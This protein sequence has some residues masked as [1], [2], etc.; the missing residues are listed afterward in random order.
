[1]VPGSW[2]TLLLVAV[3]AVVLV[4]YFVGYFRREKLRLRKW[5]WYEFYWAWFGK[6]WPSRPWG[7]IDSLAGLLGLLV[8]AGFGAYTYFGGGSV[9]K[10]VNRVRRR[11]PC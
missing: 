10:C 8:P 9:N 11:S 2:I 1:M 3:V 5:R 6:I 7:R 4:R